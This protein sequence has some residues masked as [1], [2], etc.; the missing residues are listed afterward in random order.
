MKQKNLKS[1]PLRKAENAKSPEKAKPG[2]RC[3][4]LLTQS[5]PL[6]DNTSASISDLLSQGRELLICGE[7]VVVGIEGEILEIVFQHVC[8]SLP[9]C[10]F[11]FVEYVLSLLL[12]YILVFCSMG[13]LNFIMVLE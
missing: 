3:F 10:F 2:L 1:R 13:F 11:C 12:Y 7:F 9:R 4:K 6:V 5:T 8:V